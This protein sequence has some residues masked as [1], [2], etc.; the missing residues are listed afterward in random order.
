M[1]ETENYVRMTVEEAM[2]RYGCDRSMAETVIRNAYPPCVRIRPPK[3]VAIGKELS[4]AGL[5]ERIAREVNELISREGDR[6]D[7]GW[8]RTMARVHEQRA[9]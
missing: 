5:R 7:L 4:A 8:H 9:K 1:A 3:L 6:P 2:A